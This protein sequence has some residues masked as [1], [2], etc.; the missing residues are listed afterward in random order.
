MDVLSSKQ[1][2]KI[3]NKNL[4]VILLHTFFHNEIIKNKLLQKKML[5]FLN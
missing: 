1:R 4:Y 3:I 2:V 5:D